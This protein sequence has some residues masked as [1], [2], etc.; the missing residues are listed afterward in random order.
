ML[1]EIQGSLSCY[2]DALRVDASDRWRSTLVLLSMFGPRNAVR[3]AWATL[4]KSSGRRG[5][6]GS[7][8]VGDT[9]VGL[10]EGVG[11]SYTSAPLDRGHH[12]ILIFHPMLSHNAPD[13]GYVYQVGPGAERR[14]FERLAR[15]CPVPLRAAWRERLWDLGRAAGAV[16]ETKGHGREVWRVAT[17]REV[18]E[19]IV[20]A[21]IAAKELT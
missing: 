3:A 8:A 5:R 6:T 20:R 13:L 9:R 14:Y 10:A 11:Y 21:A 17:T 4:A 18:W 1:V 15:W 19:P 2:S 12:H 7:I 16:T